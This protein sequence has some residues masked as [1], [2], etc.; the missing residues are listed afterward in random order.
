M[1]NVR[2]T[3]P[4]ELHDLV[5]DVVA[6]LESATG[7]LAA[8][9][10]EPRARA[11]R[12]ERRRAPQATIIRLPGP[13]GAPAAAP[14]ALPPPPAPAP[15]P[16]FADALPVPAA[17]PRRRAFLARLKV[18]STVP[19]VALPARTRRLPVACRRASPL[20]AARV[21]RMLR[22]AVPA[23]PV[24]P[25]TL[26]TP[27][28]WLLAAIGPA[29]PQVAARD[30]IGPALD[31]GAV[32]LAG[33][34]TETGTA[35]VEMVPAEGAAPPVPATESSEPPAPAT[36]TAPPPAAEL[37]IAPLQLPVT[38]PLPSAAPAHPIWRGAAG[39]VVN[40][41]IAAALGLVTIFCAIVVGLV[42][43]GHHLEE[44]VTGSMQPTI[45]IGSMVVTEQLPASRLQV[46]NILVFPD[47][48]DTKLT[49][50]HRIVWL[51][52]DQS[53][54]VLV[55]TKGDYNAM[56]DQWTLKRAANAEADRVFEIIP[57]GGTVAGYLQTLG[58]WG[59]ILL[60]VGV[61]GFYGIRKVRQILNEDGA[62]EGDG[63]AGETT[64]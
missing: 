31:Q 34:A 48:N 62:T 36:E 13:E 5:R 53:G 44:V 63:P 52:H 16:R 29:S 47:P 1:G 14:P 10:P 37:T 64:A 3:L 56:P 33:R 22:V 61:I 55:R 30:G 25:A 2:V 27:P 26:S 28:A 49:I 21:S 38:P 50:V 46:G 19:S 17:A 35:P 58:F 24:A 54:D 32:S 23:V 18:A 9:S 12:R 8:G 15:P 51:S 45:P 60:L 41:L 11:P 59:L 39:H 4:E 40:L 20:D 7:S 6:D 42:V 43:T 57:G